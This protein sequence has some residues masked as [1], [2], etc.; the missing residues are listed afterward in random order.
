MRL[1]ILSIL[2]TGDKKENIIAPC[3]SCS[4][5]GSLAAQSWPSLQTTFGSFWV[6]PRTRAEAEAAGWQLLSGC[7]EGA[8]F[9]GERYGHPE[10]D[11]LVLIYD[12]AGYIA[13]SQSV[14]AASAVDTS[15]VDMSRQPAYQ[16]R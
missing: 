6:Q 8:V 4:P 7:S 10:D 11:S 1:L 12:A 14:V 16:V 5:A 15:L 9:L 3:K 2:V 13:G